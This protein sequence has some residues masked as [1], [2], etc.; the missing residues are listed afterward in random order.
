MDDTGNGASVPRG[1]Q[2]GGQGEEIAGTGAGCSAGRRLAGSGCAALCVLDAGVHSV[3]QQA[4]SAGDGNGGSL[5]EERNRR[6][7][8]IKQGM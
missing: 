7:S 8:N 4:A 3:S 1:G 5:N 6:I 2:S